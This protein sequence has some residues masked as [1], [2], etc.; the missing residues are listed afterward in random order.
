MV[1]GHHLQLRSHP[2]LFHDFQHFNVKAAA[3]HHPVIQK[4]GDELLAKEAIEPSSGG[5]GFYSSVFAV[6][7]HTGDLHP[8]LN[9]KH[10]NSYMHI[11]SFKMPTLKNVWQL[12]QQGDFAFSIDL[13]HAYLHIPIVKHHCH[14]LHSPQGDTVHMLV[15]LPPDKLADIQQLALSLLCTPHVTVCKVMSFL[16]KANF[17]TNGHSRL[18]HLCCV[19]QSDMLSVHH[20]PT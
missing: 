15:S 14:F 16:G 18:Q 7:K 12:I 17:C 11:P 20:S 8:I 10:F 19:I 3:A 1:W 4:E 13:Q 5:A 6:P 9:L 2:S